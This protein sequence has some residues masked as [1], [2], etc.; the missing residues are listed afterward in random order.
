V[1]RDQCYDFL[2]FFAEKLSKKFVG[3]FAL[4]IASFLHKFDHN[5]GLREKRKFFA[6]DWQKS[7]KTSTPDEFGTILPKMKPNPSLVKN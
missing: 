5:I 4:T 7:Q 1:T 6:K 2:N 3:F